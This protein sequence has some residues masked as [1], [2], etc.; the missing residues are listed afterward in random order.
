MFGTSQ[1]L[2]GQKASQTV[3]TPQ[4]TRRKLKKENLLSAEP[5]VC[6]KKEK[7]ER[8]FPLKDLVEEADFTS[9]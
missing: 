9:S 2:E 4:M 3:E 7:K 6:K 5:L 1:S 8:H